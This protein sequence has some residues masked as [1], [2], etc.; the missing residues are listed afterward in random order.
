VS[1]CFEGKKQRPRTGSRPLVVRFIV[2]AAFRQAARHA[3]VSPAPDE[4]LA[5]AGSAA[6]VGDTAAPV[7][8][9]VAGTAVPVAVEQAA[10]AV[11]AQGVSTPAAVLGAP[12]SRVVL[13]RAAVAVP[14]HAATGRGFA[15]PELCALQALAQ[16]ADIAGCTA[17]PAYAVAAEIAAALHSAPAQA[18]VA[19]G[20]DTAAALRSAL[21]RGAVVVAA[22]DTAAAPPS[23]SAASLRALAVASVVRVRRVPGAD[24]AAETATDTAAAA[25]CS[26]HCSPVHWCRCGSAV[27]NGLRSAP[28]LPQDCE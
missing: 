5:Q 16:A 3:V 20:A 10:A 1:G 15:G 4:L 28:A 2:P 9:V 26:G 27:A 11:A 12:A 6:V 18:A 13:A 17:A 8:A 14:P 24:S 25:R 22:A 19:A 21:E 7:A 23:D